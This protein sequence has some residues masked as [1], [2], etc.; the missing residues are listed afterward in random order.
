LVLKEILELNRLICQ[1]GVNLKK[2][3]LKKIY[4]QHILNFTEIR[5]R[6]FPKIPIF[7]IFQDLLR[8]KAIKDP[9]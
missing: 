9:S 5:T 1:G 2:K 6:D 3:R 8:N 7:P 4:P